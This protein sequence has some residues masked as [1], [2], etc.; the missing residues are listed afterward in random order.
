MHL[1]A[2]VHTTCS[3]ANTRSMHGGEGSTARVHGAC[4]CIAASRLRG[5][6]CE[7]FA[8]L[9]VDTRAL[10]YS[11]RFDSRQVHL[12]RFFKP[13]PPKLQPHSLTRGRLGAKRVFGSSVT[14]SEFDER[15][16]LE[17]LDSNILISRAP[18][19]LDSA[20]PLLLESDWHRSDE[21][22]TPYRFTRSRSVHSWLVHIG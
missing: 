10:N 11:Q 8:P 7:D 12:L 17:S 19:A 21:G 2:S 13:R 1:F 15:S 3:T 14:S 4:S 16:G 6:D 9:R 5:N 22:C 20:R 18:R